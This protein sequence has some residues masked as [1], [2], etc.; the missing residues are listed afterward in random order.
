MN[1]L[2]LYSIIIVLCSSCTAYQYNVLTTDKENSIEE[3]FTFENDTLQLSYSFSDGFAEIAIVNK[4]N[5]PLY[6]DWSRSAM[7]V[8]GEAHAYWNGQSDITMTAT[9]RST[10]FPYTTD[11]SGTID[12]GVPV[13][14]IPPD[15]RLV[16]PTFDLV[17]L[18]KRPKQNRLPRHERFTMESTPLKF[19]SYLMVSTEQFFSTPI[20]L[21]NTFWLSE[22]F[23]YN[24]KMTLNPRQD[25]FMLSYTTQAGQLG[26]T[27]GLIGLIFGAAAISASTSPPAGQ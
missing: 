7:I 14:F 24:E 17:A 25:A 23:R 13:S 10:L 27:A 9:V 16:K 3:P 5:V 6:V 1:R 15:S 8:D 11:A 19:R 2:A 12:N 21:N 18:L 4:L 26:Y 22:I 20:T